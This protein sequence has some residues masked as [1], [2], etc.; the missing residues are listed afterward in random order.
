MSV[1]FSFL[2]KNLLGSGGSFRT[3]VFL[4]SHSFAA[5]EKHRKSCLSFIRSHHR[6]V[7]GLS[8][9]AGEKGVLCAE[10]F[11][12][13]SDQYRPASSD[14][15]G[16]NHAGHTPLLW[17]EQA[18]DVNMER[19]ALLMWEYHCAGC[20]PPGRCSLLLRCWI[21]AAA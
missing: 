20:P 2:S 21:D 10:H 15:A 12:E 3:A 19:A 8:S 11:T 5:H 16:G 7:E 6:R 1:Y 13:D 4:A 9:A 14:P 17:E 18:G